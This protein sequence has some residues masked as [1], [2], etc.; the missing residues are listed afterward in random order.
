MKKSLISG[1]K[2]N[3]L[4]GAAAGC[5]IMPSAAF[6]QAAPA[7]GDDLK[8]IAVI[9]VIAR[10]ATESL[11]EVPVTV[12]AIGGDTIARDQT[13]KIE[14]IGNRV[15]TLSIQPGGSG[16]GGSIALRGVGSSA[17]SAAFDSRSEERRVG[18]ECCR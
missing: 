10:K 12:T 18:K 9:T 4:V 5:L 2:L 8:D 11:Q 6:A 14:Q 1:M 13:T 15:P 17:I 3:L 7:D 16:S